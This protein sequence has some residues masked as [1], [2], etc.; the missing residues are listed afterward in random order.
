[1]QHRDQHHTMLRG[2]IINSMARCM[3]FGVLILAAA[4]AEAACMKR[5]GADAAVPG[6]ALMEPQFTLLHTAAGAGASSSPLQ[7]RQ[8]PGRRALLQNIIDQCG[9]Y[10]GPANNKTITL[11]KDV[12]TSSAAGSTITLVPPSSPPRPALPPAS[13]FIRRSGHQLIGPPD[14]DGDADGGSDADGGGSRPFYFIGCNAQWLVN[15]A[16][17]DEAWGRKE[18]VDFLV[19]VRR[20]GMRA[21]RAWA[22]NTGMP[23][24]P[25]NY[26][27]CQLEVSFM[28][29]CACA[30]VHV[31]VHVEVGCKLHVFVSCAWHACPWLAS[32]T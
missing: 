11:P 23:S 21:V 25:G 27:P 10:I 26:N 15:R 14:G 12:V 2:I 1:M 16:G 9:N 31:H 17:F 8:G 13:A 22:F 32:G 29:S 4:E 18:V 6:S 30:G 5:R 7:R 20:L 24:S 3:L 19:S 28:H